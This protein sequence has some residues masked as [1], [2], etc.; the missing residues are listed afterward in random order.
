MDE[1]KST[2]D[3]EVG[4][5]RV[6]WLLA[7]LSVRRWVN[8]I[9]GYASAAFGRRSKPQGRKGTARKSHLSASLMF[10]LAGIFLLNS[11]NLATQFLR[12]VSSEAET[13]YSETADRIPVSYDAFQAL[14]DA[15]LTIRTGNPDQRDVYERILRTMLMR[16][17]RLQAR[18]ESIMDPGETELRARVARLMRVF[19]EEGCDGFVPKRSHNMMP[20]PSTR[21]WLV[22]DGEGMVLNA[23]GLLMLLL[24]FSLICMAM[25]S[26]NQDLGRVEWHVEW[27]FSFPVSSRALFL[28]KALEYALV[29]PFN[30]FIILPLF[31]TLFVAS[32]FGWWSVLYAV[33]ASLY[34]SIIL[35][36][37]RIALET[38]LRK[39]FAV[40]RLKN[41]QAVFQVMGLLTFF[42]VIGL[43][44][45]PQLPRYLVTWGENVPAMALWNPL[46]LPVLLCGTA[47]NPWAWLALAGWMIGLPA[48]AAL[49]SSYCVSDGIVTT[50]NPY[51]GERGASGTSD[52]GWLSRREGLVGKDLR[53]LVRDRNLLVQTLVVPVLIIGFNI[54][55]NPAMLRSVLA[56]FQHAATLAFSL[57][58][59]VLLFSGFGVLTSEGPALWLL[60]TFPQRMD[61]MLRRKATLWCVFGLVYAVLVLSAA[62]SVSPEWEASQLITAGT[63]LAGV[64]IYAY[65]AVALGALGTDPFETET[66]RRLRPE[67]T[68]LYMFLAGLFAFAIYAPTVWSKIVQ[69]VLSALLAAALWQKVRDRLQYLLDPTEAP[70]PRVS[71]ADGLIA[72]LAFFV[73]QAILM[74]AFMRAQFP[75]GAQMLMAFAGAG[76]LVAVATLYLLWRRKVPQ[77][78]KAL[79]LRAD[80]SNPWSSW[81]FAS[82]V[83]VAFGLTAALMG[84]LYLQALEYFPALRDWRDELLSSGGRLDIDLKW[85]F[86]TAV[87]AAPLFEEFI[88]RGLVYRGLLRSFTR[89][90]AVLASALIFALVHPP[91]SVIPVLG[92]G[93]AAAFSFQLTGLLI[94]PIMAHMA[95]NFIVVLASAP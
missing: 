72:A 20:F 31:F 35:G 14:R 12:R 27:L 8:R 91:I 30:W 26:G 95:Y 29:N 68:Y 67:L 5:V 48:V 51:Q 28:A 76:C 84:L 38:W 43:A 85:F 34:V 23:L 50:G 10:M 93:L 32:G 21:D 78:L 94:A 80:R 71:I 41:L 46:S 16:E 52:K 70:P 75:L 58:A 2:E 45:A 57:G 89:W 90:Q 77:L 37:A 13:R 56:D 64:I 44:V 36:A 73:L 18:R 39:R 81:Y 7:R 19:H 92:L 63:A 88:F 17:A 47:P 53:L 4:T 60:Y 6:I 9:R 83:G 61:A 40:S 79:G 33:I 42:L 25:G 74:L 49:F 62:A 69:T 55:I 15:E 59:Y 87:V 65:I 54:F 24:A 82:H 22:G 11:L 1:P 86:W 3:A 66:A